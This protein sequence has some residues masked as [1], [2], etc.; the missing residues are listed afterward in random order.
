VPD[1]TGIGDV[2]GE[3][4]GEAGG[5]LSA[6]AITEAPK[7]NPE[8]IIAILVDFIFIFISRNR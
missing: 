1:G 8:A 6:L 5:A 7:I 3:G 4:D 2:D